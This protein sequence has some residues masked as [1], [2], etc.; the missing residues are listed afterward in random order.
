MGVARWA[1]PRGQSLVLQPRPKSEHLLS[2]ML[3]MSRIRLLRFRFFKKM[4]LV[5]KII[6]CK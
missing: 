3:S 4:G 6:M 2:C 1:C 5:V